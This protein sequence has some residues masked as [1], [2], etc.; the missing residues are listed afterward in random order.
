M[1]PDRATRLFEWVD[2]HEYQVCSR[3]NRSLR[4][5]PLRSY[6]STVSKLGDGWIWYLLILGMPLADPLEGSLVALQCT[7]TGLC[8]TL[9]YKLLKRRLSRERPFI[10][11][12]TIHCAVPPLDRYS[13]PSGHTLHAVCF[14]LVI[15]SNY[16][17]LGLALIPFTLSVMASRVVLG[18][19][20]PSDVAAGAIIG[21]ALAL[22]SQHN[23]QP[24]L[25][26]VLI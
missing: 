19:H 18:L 3:I 9:L 24:W 7:V 26:S 5:R 25:L 20:Y 10:S 6:F 23:L 4:Y 8:C 1:P 21:A 14:S 16:P 17:A 11:F 13:F 22:V 2:H 12:P 15:Y